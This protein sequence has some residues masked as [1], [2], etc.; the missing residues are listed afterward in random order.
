MERLRQRDGPAGWALWCVT[1]I[2]LEAALCGPAQASAP[3]GV[4]T[5]APEAD[6]YLL[7]YELN[8]PAGDVD[9]NSTP[10]DYSVD[11]SAT[12][13]QPFDRIAYT[14]ELQDAS[15]TRWVSVS[16]DA[17]TDDPTKLGVPN[18]ASG[19][20][21]QRP[22]FNMA[23]DSNVPGIVTG[24]GIDTGMIDFWPSDYYERNDTFAPNA[25]ETQYD[26]GDGGGSITSGFGSMQV[27]NY[28][29][30]GDGSGP[31]ARLCSPTI[32]GA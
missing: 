24:T 22:V 11:N 4:F 21:F 26:W 30:D 16:M 14:L 15:G 13:V 8:I 27:H 6:S 2:A 9:Y 32:I 23:I 18:V 19:A 25:S 20:F 12:I 28:D 5:N 29:L 31:S 7:V 10:I 17:F 3:A 1:I